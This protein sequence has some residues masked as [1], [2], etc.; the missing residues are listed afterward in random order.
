[1]VSWLWG[2]SRQTVSTL[3]DIKVLPKTMTDG[4]DSWWNVGLAGTTG[5]DKQ[6]AAYDQLLIDRAKARKY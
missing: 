5:V 6:K 2:R 3:I 4:Y 1:M